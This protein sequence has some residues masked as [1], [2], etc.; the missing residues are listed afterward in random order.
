MQA[1]FQSGLNISSLYQKVKASNVQS[2]VDTPANSQE[3][4]LAE[5]KAKKTKNLILGIGAAA[6]AAGTIAI[7]AIRKKNA[8]ESNLGGADDKIKAQ[9]AHLL[10][11][12]PKDMDSAKVR[13]T[14]I[15]NV[16]SEKMGIKVKPEVEILPSKSLL[17]Q[18][19]NGSFF[20]DASNGKILVNEEY[21]EELQGNLFYVSQNGKSP[22]NQI[23]VKEIVTESWKKS[24]EMAGVIDNLSLQQLTDKD[25]ALDVST[26]M[27]NA[28][29]KHQQE[30]FMAMTEG[31]GAEKIYGDA[32]I[33]LGDYI[34]DED[35]IKN[36]LV[37]QLKKVE[38]NKRI[39]QIMEDNPDISYGELL[40]HPDISKASIDKFFA[41]NKEILSKGLDEKMVKVKEIIGAQMDEVKERKTKIS[42]R[43]KDYFGTIKADSPEGKQA[44]VFYDEL[45]KVEEGDL[46]QIS[47]QDAVG[48]SYNFAKNNFPKIFG[49][50]EQ[51]A[52]RV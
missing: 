5:D 40:E 22:R 38:K 20:H 48:Y 13:L 23:G 29:R 47:E 44:Q 2:Q 16:I 14:E 28:L 11:P 49:C 25:K 43:Y 51:E 26:Y 1:Y 31:L 9:F 7:I 30:E 15:M 33:A 32:E 37:E 17:E 10:E 45:M 39:Q 18:G 50:S 41:D 19:Y 21:L 27:T 12:I 6:V 42:Q 8:S 52:V 34:K 46:N 3:N 35:S 24:R 4:L 36:N